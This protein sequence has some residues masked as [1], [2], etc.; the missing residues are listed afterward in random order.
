[1]DNQGETWAL[2]QET[3]EIVA[4]EA[5]LFWERIQQEYGL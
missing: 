5:P 4:V 3:R 2:N 1:M